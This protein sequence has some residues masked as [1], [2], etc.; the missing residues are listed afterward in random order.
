VEDQVLWSIS[1]IAG[2]RA[3]TDRAYV[4]VGK[5]LD[6]FRGLT[7]A[8]PPTGFEVRKSDLPRTEAT[9]PKVR[10]CFEG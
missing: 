3:E 10:F 9:S 6:G 7:D 5:R 8:M 1:S 2:Y 4:T